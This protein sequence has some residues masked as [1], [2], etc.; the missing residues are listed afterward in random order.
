MKRWFLISMAVAF[1]TAMFAY[2][3]ATKDQ[4]IDGASCCKSIGLADGTVAIAVYYIPDEDAD[5]TEV[6]FPATIEVW[7]GE[8]AVKTAEYE[9]SQIGYYSDAMWIQHGGVN[10]AATMTAITIPEGVKTIGQSTFYG[11]AAM[12]TLTLPATLEKINSYAFGGCGALTKIICKGNTAPTLGDDVFK[13]SDGEWDKTLNQAKVYV[14][15]DEAKATYNTA[16]WSYWQVWF[17]AD[18]IV[19]DPTIL[20]TDDDPVVE[21]ENGYYLSGD[22]VEWKLDQLKDYKFVKNEDNTEVEEYTIEITLVK[23]QKILPCKIE[24]NVVTT[25]Y[26]EDGSF[27]VTDAYVGKKI[28]RFRPEKNSEWT[29]CDGHLY[30]E[31]NDD[32]EG[33]GG[34]TPDPDPEPDPEPDPDPTPDPTPDP[35]PADPTPEP[36]DQAIDNTAVEMYTV[37]TFENG[38]LIIIKNGVKYNANGTI[39]K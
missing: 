37:K 28:V 19:V 3:K 6:K 30:I 4:V 21:I 14:P 23:D 29:M 15:S 36:E 26:P 17:N 22:H 2:D 8:P 39:L 7:E 20:D 24:S 35:D 18:A 5:K 10:K 1:C 34:E 38:Q 33:E 27:T 31:P 12:T 11:T 25:W 13:Y 32:G 16:D 9:V